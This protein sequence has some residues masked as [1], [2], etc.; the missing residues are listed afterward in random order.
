MYYY[1]FLKKA[2]I[3]RAGGQA[4]D[5]IFKVLSTFS[6]HEVAIKVFNDYARIYNNY[7]T[8]QLSL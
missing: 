4:T 3:Q 6:A 5:P 2:T 1:L 7:T 8:Q